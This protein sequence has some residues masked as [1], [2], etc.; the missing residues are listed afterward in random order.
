MID[1]K[2]KHLET[3]THMQKIYTVLMSKLHKLNNWQTA[4]ILTVFSFAIYSVGL[5]DPFIGDDTEQIVNNTPVHSISNLGLFFKGGT[6]YNG[7]RL[8]G[9]YYR[10]FMTTVY[11][12]VYSL[13]GPHPFYFHIFQLVVFMGSALLLYLFFRFFF[14]PTLSLVLTLLFVVHPIDSQAVY[15]IACMQDVLFLFFGILGLYLLKKNSS[16]KSLLLVAVCLLISLFSK[17]TGVLFVFMAAVLLFWQD[18]R[19]LLPF[20]S[21]MLVPITLWFVLKVHAIGL[22]PNPSNAPI[23]NLDFYARLLTMPSLIQFYITKF[24]F[25]FKIASEYYWVYKK[26]SVTHVL[27]PLIIDLAVVGLIIYTSQVIRKKAPKAQYHAFLFFAIWCA[28]GLL[29]DLQI[30]PLDMTASAVWFYFP[31]VGVLGMIGVVANNAI[32]KIKAPMRLKSAII[33]ILLIGLAAISITQGFQ[34]RNPTELYTHDIA[35]SKEDFAAYSVLGTDLFNQGNYNQ[36]KPYV[37]RSISIYPTAANYQT[38]GAIYTEEGNFHGA[39]D[40]FNMAAKYKATATSTLYNDIADLTLVLGNFSSNSLYIKNALN[41]YPNDYQLWLILALLD[42][43]NN[44]NPDAKYAIYEASINGPVPSAVVNYIQ[45]NK[46][47]Y[48]PLGPR[49]VYI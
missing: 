46:P 28:V 1:N 29:V 12:I 11:S 48:I 33:V 22:S 37:V 32:I 3:Y 47:F 43:K 39:L 31:M 49:N 35:D 5:F 17:E 41:Y 23:D 20:V 25:P 40:A 24:I 45:S 4:I 44:D 9:V 16:I 18:R 13:F 8:T 19:R 21:I 36:A 38:L 42:Q 10:P 2:S 14:Q 15:A 30:I 6:F 27:V 34:W 7:Q 26:F